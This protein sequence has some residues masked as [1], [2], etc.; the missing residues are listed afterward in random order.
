MSLPNTV[1]IGEAVRA[2]CV[3]EESQGGRQDGSCCQ[4]RVELKRNGGK[5]GG[6]ELGTI[7]MC[8]H[9]DTSEIENGWHLCL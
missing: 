1:A 3:M 7:T 9:K 5:Y 4:R 6:A 2:E 8:S